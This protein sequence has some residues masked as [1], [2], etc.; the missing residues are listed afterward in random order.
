MKKIFKILSFLFILFTIQLGY[1]QLSKTHYIPPLSSTF[2]NN[3]GSDNAPNEQWFHISTPSENAVNFTIKRGDGTDF[4]TGTVSNAVPW[5]DRANLGDNQNDQFGY[6]F[7]Q[8][9]SQEQILTQHGFIIEADE[10]IY[11]S[12]RFIARSNNHGGALVSKGE[13]ALGNRFR[14]GSLQVGG[15]HMSFF[16]LMATDDN[17]FVT[18]NLPAGVASLAGSTG[19]INVGPLNRGQSYIIGNNETRNGIIGSLIESTKP[20][21]VNSGSGVGSFSPGVAGAGGQDFGVDQIVGVD[22]V[23]SST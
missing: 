16:S 19:T 11:V 1:S 17:T 7:A 23:G 10:E 14:T 15:D 5:T 13:S 2:A 9:N 18:I 20:I 21:V 12:A 4:A 8:P 3:A 6:L 22:L